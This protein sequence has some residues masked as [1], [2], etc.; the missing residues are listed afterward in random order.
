MSTILN[1]TTGVITGHLNCISKSKNLNSIMSSNKINVNTNVTIGQQVK[2]ERFDKIREKLNAQ[3]AYLSPEYVES[4]QEACSKQIKSKEPEAIAMPLLQSDNSS[5]FFDE[6]SSPKKDYSFYLS[7]SS[8]DESE[9]E[10]EPTF[11]Q[12]VIKRK[13][14]KPHPISDLHSSQRKRDQLLKRQLSQEVQE[15]NFDSCNLKEVEGFSF[16]DPDWT[17]EEPKKNLNV[18]TKGYFVVAG[19]TTK[20]VK[21]AL[22]VRA[23]SPPKVN[24]IYEAEKDPFYIPPNKVPQEKKKFLS[25][26]DHKAKVKAITEEFEAENESTHKVAAGPVQFEFVYKT[27]ESEPDFKHFPTSQKV[28]KIGAG[29]KKYLTNRHYDQQKYFFKRDSGKVIEYAE[30]VNHKM[31]KALAEGILRDN[32]VETQVYLRKIKEDSHFS[33]R[34]KTPKEVLTELEAS[35]PESRKR[36]LDIVFGP[37]KGKTPS[38]S[39]LNLPPDLV[40]LLEEKPITSFH[41]QTIFSSNFVVRKAEDVTSVSLPCMHRQMFKKVTKNLVEQASDAVTSKINIEEVKQD[42]SELKEDVQRTLEKARDAFDSITDVS[43]TLAPEARTTLDSVR[44]TS[45]SLEQTVKDFAKDITTENIMSKITDK[46][47]SLFQSAGNSWGRFI[48]P[49]TNLVEVITDFIVYREASLQSILIKISCY[50]S[51][52]VADLIAFVNRF[53]HQCN[54][55]PTNIF[56][57]EVSSNNSVPS[58]HLQSDCNFSFLSK[59]IPNWERFGRFFSV[60]KNIDNGIGAIK[61]FLNWVYDHLPNFLRE[62][63]SYWVPSFRPTYKD[64]DNLVK[65]CIDTETMILKGE[66]IDTVD[67]NEINE[68]IDNFLK[69]SKD[70]KDPQIGRIRTFLQNI[71]SR[72]LYHANFPSETRRCPY[73]VWLMGESRDGKSV[74][75]KHMITTLANLIQTS[76]KPVYT[77][78]VGTDYWDGYSGEFGVMYDDFGQSKESEEYYE[79]FQACTINDY[80]LP[81]A[82]LDSHGVGKKGTKFTSDLVWCCTNH[83]GTHTAED[84]VHFVNALRNRF[85]IC[86][87]SHKVMDANGQP[88]PYDKS[89]MFGHMTFTIHKIADF[90]KDGS[91]SVER[92]KLSYEALLNYLIDSFAKHYANQNS[93]LKQLRTDMRKKVTINEDAL[94]KLR[95]LVHDTEHEEDFNEP[96]KPTMSLRKEQINIQQLWD[97]AENSPNGILSLSKQMNEE[98]VSLKRRN[99]TIQPLDLPPRTSNFEQQTDPE[100]KT[101]YQSM[102]HHYQNL[103]SKG[104]KLMHDGILGVAKNL[105]AKAWALGKEVAHLTFVVGIASTISF[106]VIQWFFKDELYI[107]ENE[108]HNDLVNCMADLIIIFGSNKVRVSN[109]LAAARAQVVGPMTPAQK[110]EHITSCVRTCTAFTTRAERDAWKKFSSYHFKQL[111]NYQID[112]QSWTE[113]NVLPLKPRYKYQLDEVDTTR[114]KEG[115]RLAAQNEKV[116]HLNNALANIPYYSQQGY[117]SDPNINQDLAKISKNVYPVGMFYREKNSED[118]KRLARMHCTGIHQHLYLMNHHL[119]DLPNHYVDDDGSEVEWYLGVYYYGPNIDPLM[120]RFDPNRVTKLET[121]AG[122]QLDAVI[123][124]FYGTHIPHAPSIINRFIPNMKLSTL[125]EGADVAMITHRRLQQDKG[126]LTILQGVGKSVTEEL[127]YWDEQ[128]GKFDQAIKIFGYTMATMDGDCGS[129]VILNHKALPEKLIGIH[130]LGSALDCNGGCTIITQEILKKAM[131]TIVCGGYNTLQ[132]DLEQE[133]KKQFLPSP[134]LPRAQEL[135]NK[136]ED[137][138]RNENPEDKIDALMS[139]FLSLHQVRKTCFVETPLRKHFLSLG[140]EIKNPANLHD[141]QGNDPVEASTAFYTNIYVN[142]LTWEDVTVVYRSYLPRLPRPTNFFTDLSGNVSLLVPHK[143]IPRKFAHLDSMNLRTSTGFPMQP[144]GYDKRDLLEVTSEDGVTMKPEVEEAMTAL[145]TEVEV[146][147]N[148]KPLVTIWTVSL[149]DELLKEGKLARTFEIPPVLY[150]FLV[151]RYF[152]SFCDAFQGA[153]LSFDSAV[154]INP[155]SD[156]WSK[157]FYAITQF[158]EDQCWDGD[159]NKW[160]KTVAT[161]AINAAVEMINE[162]YQMYDPK[163]NTSDDNIRR[164][165]IYMMSHGP[166]WLK[167]CLL[168][169]VMGLRTG[170]PMT[171]VLNTIANMILHGTCYLKLAPP[172]LRS[173]TDYFLHTVRFFYGDDNIFGGSRR[174]TGFFNRVS[175]SK[176]FKRHVGMDMTS[177]AKDGLMTELSHIKNLTFLKRGFLREVSS[178]KIKPTLSTTSI[179]SMLSW[180]RTSAHCDPTKQLRVNVDVALAF[181]YFHGPSVFEIITQVLNKNGIK[182]F[183][184]FQYYHMNWILGNYEIFSPIQN[185]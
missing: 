49:I 178:T 39:C 77:R 68:R 66:Q 124:N 130:T 177:G 106:A 183:R 38:P 58:L 172:K 140:L 56:D 65:V 147:L 62:F 50:F 150:T 158:G 110:R 100:A 112:E 42:V 90:R 43:T 120:V 156:Q 5:R 164:N 166:L 78:N 108:Y 131:S 165:L 161:I 134:P 145:M 22:N 96:L 55:K 180:V 83:T 85:N 45:E 70:D 44:K 169:I 52:L 125:T 175:I 142:S 95:N 15:L 34:K 136:I 155:E 151:R 14:R 51:R 18:P 185:A 46:L 139:P 2:S 10:V 37:F 89:G 173:M 153:A 11:N 21:P 80:I 20:Y 64:L 61:T 79:I 86:I 87:S 154:G 105:V 26:K 93:I 121:D 7:D 102:L 41:H 152:G 109:T 98:Q 33:L 92:S 12:H 123:Y 1:S 103:E 71:K 159:F 135:Q 72:V 107:A 94:M 122:R 144:A 138:N 3:H 137:V 157:I 76:K 163:W 28:I 25:R 53:G 176:W 4:L 13:E 67:V 24:Y 117:F 47:S 74:L 126:E 128:T 149:K 48:F 127:S 174:V 40:S 118:Y 27:K 75:A 148:K 23:P 84:K 57:D 162:W 99:S 116:Q 81:M 141:W 32:L 36:V 29:N 59:I 132:M 9:N 133:G 8:E 104:R 73:G 113:K 181:A 91:L 160:D 31:D 60:F 114:V 115:L 170:H 111:N 143:Y 129:V 179:F 69:D 171:A 63:I 168:W 6:N 82:S 101:F 167:N 182:D 35:T 88:L 16:E 17:P 30:K 184:P 119:V 19:T 54:H 146:D 97:T